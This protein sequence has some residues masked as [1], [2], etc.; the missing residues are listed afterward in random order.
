[1]S[2]KKSEDFPLLIQTL[3][4]RLDLSQVKLAEQ[5]GI[6]F[7]TVNSWENGRNRPSQMA[8]ILIQEKLKAMKEEGV[9][10]LEK[11]F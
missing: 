11:Y 8:I 4:E 7:K 1:M 10:L 9:D 5:L 3:R 6:S 2:F